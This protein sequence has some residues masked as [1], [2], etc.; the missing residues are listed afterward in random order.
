MNNEDVLRTT[1]LNLHNMFCQENDIPRHTYSN[2]DKN[3]EQYM[4]WGFSEDQAI[5]LSWKRCEAEQ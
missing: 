2:F 1:M 3:F 4:K 5:D